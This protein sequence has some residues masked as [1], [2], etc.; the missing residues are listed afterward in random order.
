MNPNQQQYIEDFGLFAEEIGLTRMAGRILAWLLICDPPHQT[1]HELVDALQA[2]KSSISTTTR[3]LITFGMLEKVSL[4][5]ERRDYYR[6]VPDLW[7]TA[8][9][10]S[11]KQYTGFLRMANRG[12]D[13]LDGEPS[14]RRRRLEEMHDLYTFI[15]REFPEI[16]EHWRRERSG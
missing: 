7:T 4:P 12:L 15:A 13:L 5:G 1:M 3:M 14:E 16:L 6:L 2:S 9:E 10:R 8:M 11:V